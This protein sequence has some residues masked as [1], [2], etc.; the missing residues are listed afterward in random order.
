MQHSNPIE[1]ISNDEFR[2][3]LTE[4]T[5]YLKPFSLPKTDV[6]AYTHQYIDFDFHK[7]VGNKE[8]ASML[9]L[10]IAREYVWP[11]RFKT[12]LLANPKG[13]DMPFFIFTNDIKNL[14]DGILYQFEYFDINEAAKVLEN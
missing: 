2:W 8:L 11:I 1:D 10:L 5:Q 7:Q 3:I 12:A 4:H 14:P 13:D 9:V 6:V